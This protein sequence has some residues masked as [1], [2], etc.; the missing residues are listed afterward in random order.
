MQF[1]SFTFIVF[2]IAVLAL[3]QLLP[4]WNSQKGLLLTASYAFYAAWSPPLVVL[5]WLSTLTDFV[6]ARRMHRLTA[7]AGRRMLLVASLGV[8]LGL[9]GY[10][11]YADFFLHSFQG[12][13]VMVG[14]VYVP[15]AFDIILPIGI[16]LA[17][18]SILL[19]PE[20]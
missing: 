4:T 20:V 15:P 5:I 14:V 9:L 2:F 19:G 12:V 10:F 13:A 1:D 16:S 7:A 11:K 6:I 17:L 8:N 3:Y 18:L